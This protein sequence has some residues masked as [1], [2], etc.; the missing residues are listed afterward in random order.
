MKLNRL[1]RKA[2]VFIMKA[3]PNPDWVTPADGILLASECPL[4]TRAAAVAAFPRQ[5]AVQVDE[6][7]AQLVTLGLVREVKVAPEDSV[8]QVK[9]SSALPPLR[10]PL[11]GNDG[12]HS[13]YLVTKFGV[14]TIN[15]FL[16]RRGGRWA[17]KG[18]GY[19]LS[20][21]A[22]KVLVGVLIGGGL[23]WMLS[24]FGINLPHLP[25]GSGTAAPTLGLSSASEPA[26]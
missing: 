12:G 15:G 6:V 11:A 10:L 26:K 14:E 4:P 3:Y 7:I 18:L 1:E 9:V 20:T 16:T 22:V 2:L 23:V 25:G 24:Q 17:V 19:L 8:K 5:P 21:D 13:A